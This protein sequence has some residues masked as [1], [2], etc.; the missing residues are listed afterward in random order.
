[1]AKLT[2]ATEAVNHWAPE[3]ARIDHLLHNLDD[4]LPETAEGQTP[5][6]EE[7]RQ[8][9]EE[10]LLQARLAMDTVLGAYSRVLFH[11]RTVIQQYQPNLVSHRGNGQH[12]QRGW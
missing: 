7:T 11:E 2:T 6:A 1:M 12:P 9:V 3:A 4:L 5:I 8:D 10:A